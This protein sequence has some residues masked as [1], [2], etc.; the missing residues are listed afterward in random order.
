MRV[1]Q[2]LRLRRWGSTA[3]ETLL[4]DACNDVNLRT[5]V[6]RAASSGHVAAV[7]ALVATAASPS[8]VAGGRAAATDRVDQKKDADDVDVVVNCRDSFGCTAAEI[9]AVAG[10]WVTAW[11]LATGG[12]PSIAGHAGNRAGGSAIV[13]SVAEAVKRGN[14]L[15]RQS[16][17]DTA[18]TTTAIDGPRVIHVDDSGLNED[19][20]DDDDDSGGLF[21]DDDDDDDDDD[22]TKMQRRRARNIRAAKTAR[23]RKKKSVA[24]ARSQEEMYIAG[25]VLDLDDHYDFESLWSASVSEDMTKKKKKKCK[26]LTR[27]KVPPRHVLRH[28]EID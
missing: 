27:K 22:V 9:A 7:L 24:A 10:H 18:A 16:I 8:S 11:A 13:P 25:G 26:K 19:E 14:E 5:A 20:T 28:D 23:A 4:A 6:A 1:D 17:S 21:S 15:A 12:S 2:R 3:A